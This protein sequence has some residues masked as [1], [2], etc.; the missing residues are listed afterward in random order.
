MCAL[1][2]ER[3]VA[4]RSHETRCLNIT[5]CCPNT[6]VMGGWHQT[7]SKFCAEHRNLEEKETSKQLTGQQVL[8]EHSIVSEREDVP[9][10]DNDDESLLTGCK[11]AQNIQRF[12][13]RTAGIL[14]VVR[15][16]GIVVNFAEMF[17]C[18]SPTQA[19]IFLFNTF[20]R[21]LAD[22]SRLH[23]LGYDRTC[24]LRT[25]IPWRSCKERL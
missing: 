2:K 12:H 8:P 20:A 15:P 9:L 25:S 10:P 4:G 21:S 5:Q 24:D 11:K 3:A 17:M 6:P 23:F 22:L 7:P 14:A 18:E 16:C 13:D 19:Y 1:P